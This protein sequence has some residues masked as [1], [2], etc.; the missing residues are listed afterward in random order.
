MFPEDANVKNNYIV[1]NYCTVYQ[2]TLIGGPIEHTSS[3]FLASDM[4][5]RITAQCFN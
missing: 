5:Q 1:P 4:Q 2:F 3:A